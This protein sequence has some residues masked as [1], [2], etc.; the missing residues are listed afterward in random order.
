MI[1]T[2]IS[3]CLS[4][5]CRG[6][7][8]FFLFLETNSRGSL[9]IAMD[10]STCSV[11]RTGP[12]HCHGLF[13]LSHDK[14]IPCLCTV[15]FRTQLPFPASTERLLNCPRWCSIRTALDNV[16]KRH[17]SWLVALGIVLQGGCCSLSLCGLEREKASL[18]TVLISFI[19]TMTSVVCYGYSPE[20]FPIKQTSYMLACDK[21]GKLLAG[22]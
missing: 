2:L 18:V 7:Y 6:G 15:P 13:R 8:G 1:S 20:T 10:P 21:E 14:E 17:L 11:M 16:G 9:H 22:L 3:S 5:E 12:G 4:Q 19:V